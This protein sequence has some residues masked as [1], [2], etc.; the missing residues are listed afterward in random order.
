MRTYKASNDEKESFLEVEIQDDKVRFNAKTILFKDVE[1]FAFNHYRQYGNYYGHIYS[2]IEGKKEACL[3]S[4]EFKG[5]N[6]LSEEMMV[7][8]YTALEEKYQEYKKN[9]PTQEKPQTQ[10]TTK[11]LWGMFDMIN[12]P[13]RSLYYDYNGNYEI[14]MFFLLAFALVMIFPAFLV[15]YDTIYFSKDIQ[16]LLYKLYFVSDFKEYEAH[17]ADVA[18]I[19]WFGFYIA[20]TDMFLKQKYKLLSFMSYDEN[21]IRVGEVATAL[22][23]LLYGFVLIVYIDGEQVIGL[24]AISI[25]TFY[26]IFL[27]YMEHKK[28]K[29]SI[30]VFVP[31]L[32]VSF[33]N[34]MALLLWAL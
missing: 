3:Y 21:V 15:N 18:V 22:M 7:E 11:K 16:E 9:H 20:I 31:Y 29:S 27:A 34:I 17:G 14:N 32:V 25:M 33:V 2:V 24:V 30:L 28:Q 26:L 13:P 6:Y 5:N 19:A 8:I 10:K 23:V 12:V 1:A 4:R